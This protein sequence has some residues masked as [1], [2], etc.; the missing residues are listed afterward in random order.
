VQAF[1]SIV[2]SAPALAS[3]EA[4]GAVSW[5]EQSPAPG[6]RNYLKMQNVKIKIEELPY[7]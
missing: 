4:A 6:I 3:Q 2:S 5:I 7:F 1:D